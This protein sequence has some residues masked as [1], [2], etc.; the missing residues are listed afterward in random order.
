MSV[1]IFSLILEDF[2]IYYFE[3]NLILCPFLYFICR[4]FTSGQDFQMKGRTY[5]I[6][7]ALLGISILASFKW[8]FLPYAESQFIRLITYA[9][10]GLTALMLIGSVVISIYKAGSQLFRSWNHLGGI[11]VLINLVFMYMLIAG[12]LTFASL[13]LGI[14]P[15][16]TVKYSIYAFVGLLFGVLVFYMFMLLHK[17]QIVADEHILFMKYLDA[18][19]EDGDRGRM[20]SREMDKLATRLEDLLESNK[21]YLET[22]LS[23]EILSGR[24]KTSRKALSHLF[25]AHYKK[26][27][28]QFIGE[29]RARYAEKILKEHKHLSLDAISEMSGY[30]ST[31]TFYKYF[32]AEYQ[33]TPHEYIENEIVGEVM[34]N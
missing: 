11:M 17:I 31:S 14:E 20:K 25:N 23:L 8:S 21:L 15:D 4:M 3:L 24:L 26:G 9:L 32:K 13:Y 29:Y 7:L 10:W 33:C 27:F 12:T 18:E 28:Y 19:L 5:F 6:F 1:S 2:T 30:T 16:A 34:S 22:D